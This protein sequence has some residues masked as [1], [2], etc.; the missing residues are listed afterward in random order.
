MIYSTFIDQDQR[1]TA[2]PGVSNLFDRRAKCTNFKL[3]AGQ[4]T[5]GRRDRE[6][7]GIE[8]EGNGEGVSPSPAD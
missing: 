4:T 3:V 5:E 1:V 6:A 8:G 2:K 7:E